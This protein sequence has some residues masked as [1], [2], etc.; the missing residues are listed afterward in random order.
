MTD[1]PCRAGTNKP[2]HVEQH[3]RVQRI[4]V[5]RRKLKEKGRIQYFYHSSFSTLP[6][7]DVCNGQ[8]E[9]W[10]T[11]PHIEIGAENY[12]GPCRP[13]NIIAH[14]NHDDEKYLFLVT[15]CRNK[16]MPE[17]DGKSYFVGY[18]EKSEELV[19]QDV[20]RALKGKA[21]LFPFEKSVPYS[22]IF[23]H[24][25]PIGLVD[26]A[27]TKTL[28]KLLPKAPEHDRLAFLQDCVEE[29][30]QL[31]ERNKKDKKTCLVLRGKDCS[32]RSECLRWNPSKQCS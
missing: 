14:L 4:P 7:R 26:E 29:I 12:V 11:E 20:R 19:T 15:T 23:Q 10:K 31:D 21:F 8:G 28:L 16:S 3:T 27:L 30:K 1:M 6:V 9:G 13:T 18:V 5:G 2:D 17:Y 25:A 22:T 24:F 32:F